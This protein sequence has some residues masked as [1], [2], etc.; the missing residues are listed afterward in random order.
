[1]ASFW[2]RAGGIECFHRHVSQRHDV[3]APLIRDGA[4]RL[5]FGELLDALRTCLGSPLGPMR[6]RDGTCTRKT[7][8][9]LS[10]MI[11]HLGASIPVVNG[12]LM[13]KRMV[14]KAFCGCSKYW[15]WCH[16]PSFSRSL[17]QAALN[18]SLVLVVANNQLPIPLRGE[19]ICLP[20]FG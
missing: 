14:E 20:E 2:Q 12:A 17:N 9:G 19:P 10:P 7:Q 3:F 8:G 11:S 6:A 16:R 13:A 18:D 1:M 4:G 15:G 5:A